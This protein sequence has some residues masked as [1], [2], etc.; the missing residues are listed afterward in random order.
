MWHARAGVT[1]SVTCLPQTAGLGGRTRAPTTTAASEAS[2]GRWPVH[3]CRCV[4][5]PPLSSALSC[6]CSR[7]YSCSCCSSSSSRF[8]MF[9]VSF[10]TQAQA[11]ATLHAPCLPICTSFFVWSWS[12]ALAEVFGIGS[13]LAEVYGEGSTE[14]CGGG[15]QRK[16]G[17]MQ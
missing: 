9:Q 7:R 10:V 13:A 5:E 4:S 11:G 15:G 16:A 2:A 8:F 3:V 12:C 6:C 1:C 17:Q 14:L